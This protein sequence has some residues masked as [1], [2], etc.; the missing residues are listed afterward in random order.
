MK[1]QEFKDVY[2]LT[3]ALR[4][5]AQ[6]PCQQPIQAPVLSKEWAADCFEQLDS[7]EITKE[8]DM[9]ETCLARL[10]SDRIIVS[11]GGVRKKTFMKALDEME[12][13]VKRT[14]RGDEV[15]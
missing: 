3:L 11:L 12:Q 1:H 4:K 2:K 5:L 15:V 6:Q 8:S 14:K 7:N 9:C 10:F 13:L